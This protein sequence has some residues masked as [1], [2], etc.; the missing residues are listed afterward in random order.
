MYYTNIPKK[1]CIIIPSIQC[2]NNWYC[3]ILTEPWVKHQLIF[4]T[5]NCVECSKM[6]SVV[7]KPAFTSSLAAVNKCQKLSSGSALSPP[8]D[9]SS[10]EVLL[11]LLSSLMCLPESS[12][13]TIIDQIRGCRSWRVGHLALDDM[14]L[15]AC[16]AVVREIRS[17]VNTK[18]T[19]MWL[20]EANSALITRFK[21]SRWLFVRATSC[22]SKLCMLQTS[23][24][25]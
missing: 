4:I 6:Q 9:S 14:V 12:F 1:Q 15:S 16:L 3:I 5:C 21:R 22:S 10:L 8:P 17:I 18:S 11:S 7:L 20:S 2:D 23:R 13:L 24:C 19:I 25:N